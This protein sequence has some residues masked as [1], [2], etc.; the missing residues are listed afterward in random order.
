HNLA[1]FCCGCCSIQA[2]QPIVRTACVFA[3][4]DNRFIVCVGRVPFYCEVNAHITSQCAYVCQRCTECVTSQ[5]GYGCSY[6][7]WCVC[8][9]ACVHQ[10]GF[11]F[12]RGNQIAQGCARILQ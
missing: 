2:Q 3:D 10:V 7:V 6:H 5:Q 4:S 12:D 8:D 9:C 1:C 11:G